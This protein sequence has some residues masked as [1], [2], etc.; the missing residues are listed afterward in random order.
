[1]TKYIKTLIK[2]LTIILSFTV[3]AL[4]S[5][6][7]AFSAA[8]PEFKLND[9]STDN[10][11]LFTVSMT[12]KCDKKLSAA[13]FEFT[14]DKSMFEFRSSK[15][16]DKTSKVMSNELDKSVKLIF[17]NTDGQNIKSGECLF[18]LTFKAI[19]GGTG[20][21][22]FYVS[23]CVD[24]DIK[25]IDAGKC[26]AAKITVNS[27][28]VNSKNSSDNNNNK[29][30]KNSKGSK[31]SYE[32]EETTAS[33]SSFDEIGLLNSFDNP[34]TRFLIIGIALG[35][36]IIILILLAKNVYKKFRKH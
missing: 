4:Y 6:F 20:Y 19:K 8:E 21:I 28:S 15:A 18:T 26:T 31:S 35:A 17:L 33:V 24:S 23:D 7:S 36:A 10:N 29:S 3:L 25:S 2:I 1:M 14:Y 34:D 12:A 13:S 32:K 16:Y 30:G 27:K 11:R 9:V 22:D 5:D